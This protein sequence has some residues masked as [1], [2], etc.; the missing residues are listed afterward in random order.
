MNKKTQLLLTS[1]PLL[2]AVICVAFTGAVTDIPDVSDLTT[3]EGIVSEI[4]SNEYYAF[5]V[6]YSLNGEIIDAWCT[7]STFFTSLYKD[8][9]IIAEE[10]HVLAL[11]N[12]GT[13]TGTVFDSIPSIPE[14]EPEQEP[15]PEPEPL[16]EVTP[17]PE[18]PQPINGSETEPVADSPIT[19]PNGFELVS[20][21]VG[22]T[23][24]L[25]APEGKVKI[26]VMAQPILEDVIVYPPPG[27]YYVDAGLKQ[28][29]T[30]SIENSHWAFAYWN[31]GMGA[32]G[33]LRKSG[34]GSEHYI[35]VTL[36]RDMVI[37][38]F[39]NEVI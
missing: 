33:S 19:L 28:L 20:T 18:E 11:V 29:F 8:G 31:L 21:T 4:R 10:T 1:I 34:I 12:P 39:L 6:T 5:K 7:P 17:E 35:R 16:P 9:Q 15:E 37:T 26:T 3:I 2:I 30:C 14:P 24:D 13:N 36:D 38:A 27:V 25:M 22:P 23:P 32:D